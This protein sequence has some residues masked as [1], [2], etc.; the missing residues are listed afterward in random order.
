MAGPSVP[1]LSSVSWLLVPL[2]VP[3][4]LSVLHLLGQSICC[5]AESGGK[6]EGRWVDI[7]HTGLGTTLMT[8]FK[9]HHLP[10]DPL[11]K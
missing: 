4:C 9:L 8:S 1:D 7:S 3:Q 6:A 2:S 5:H 11:S 10:V